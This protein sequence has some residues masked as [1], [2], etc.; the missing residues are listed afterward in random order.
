MFILSDACGGAKE[1]NYRCG[2]GDI[3][4]VDCH[5][6][7]CCYNDMDNKCYYPVQGLTH[8]FEII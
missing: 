7:G 2:P 1:Q 4:A 3:S 5:R 8:L 6:D